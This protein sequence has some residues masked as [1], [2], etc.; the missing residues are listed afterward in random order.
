MCRWGATDRRLGDGGQQPVV[1]GPRLDRGDPQAGE[2]ARRPPRRARDRP[3]RGAGGRVAIGPDVDPGQRPARGAPPSRRRASPSTRSSGRLSAGPR[4]VGMMQNAQRES[5][6]FCTFRKARV[7]PGRARGVVGAGRGR[8]PPR[9]LH[10]LLRGPVG[11]A[12]QGGHR[13]PRELGRRSG[14]R[15]SPTRRP[16][17]RRAPRLASRRLLR[18]AS[19]VSAQVLTTCTSAAS[20]AVSTCPASRRASRISA[21][22]RLAH[23]AAQEAHR[24]ARRGAQP[25]RPLE[26]AAGREREGHGHEGGRLGAQDGAAQPAHRQAR[27]AGGGDLGLAEPRLRAHHQAHARRCA[28]LGGEGRR[29]RRIASRVDQEALPG[30]DLVHGFRER[31]QPPQ[32]RQRA[33]PDWRAALRATR[34]ADP[35]G[36]P[37]RRRRARGAPARSRPPPPPPPRAR[38]PS[39]PGCPGAPVDEPLVQGHGHGRRGH[40]ARGA[41]TRTRAR[42][43]RPRPARPP[44]AC[45]PRR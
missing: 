40:G 37:R 44:S 41:R 18:S 43:P 38:P 33:W 20:G 13:R 6:P 9:M 34:G 5:H 15:R 4:V 11:R 28:L 30:G 12:R 17:P 35:G 7:R 39:R 8:P 32:P 24:E 19:T 36:A 29:Q 22:V 1:H 26:G 3:G 2:P 21:G 42:D 23:L 27:R 16:G 45:P 25:G 14:W 10:D 31:Y